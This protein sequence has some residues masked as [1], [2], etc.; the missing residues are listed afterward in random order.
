MIDK[1]LN[2]HNASVLILGLTFKENCPD[3]RNSKVFDVINNLHAQDIKIDVFDPF[4]NSLPDSLTNKANLI[5][6]PKKNFMM[7]S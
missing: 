2:I 1:E 6:T 5:N 3:T 7:A 4:I